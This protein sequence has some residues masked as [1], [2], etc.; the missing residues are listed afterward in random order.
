MPAP[1]PTPPPPTGVAGMRY[2]VMRGSFG[3]FPDHATGKV[4]ERG[5]LKQAAIGAGFSC[6][7]MLPAN[8]V[9]NCLSSKVGICQVPECGACTAA[10]HWMHQQVLPV[11]RW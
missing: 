6:N 10:P 1:K 9:Q 8:V 7:P 11:F 4:V 2:T 3:S 5:T